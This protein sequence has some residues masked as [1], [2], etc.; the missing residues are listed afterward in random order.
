MNETTRRWLYCVL[1]TGSVVLTPIGGIWG[2]F[3]TGSGAA[4]PGQRNNQRVR[5][6]L[7][8]LVG[9]APGNM[10][11]SASW[12]SSAMCPSSSGRPPPVRWRLSV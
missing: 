9:T 1:I 2:P 6:A 10:S 5:R 3:D 4:P 11:S 7:S 12:S 8:W